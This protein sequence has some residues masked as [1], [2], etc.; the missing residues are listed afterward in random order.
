MIMFRDDFYEWLCAINSF[1]ISEI[2]PRVLFS[3]L[4]RKNCQIN[5]DMPSME[6]DF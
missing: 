5:Y 6:D 3:E 1:L 2:D 4:R